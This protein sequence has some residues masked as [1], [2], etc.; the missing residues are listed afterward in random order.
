MSKNFKPLYVQVAEKLTAQFKEG[1]S[2][3]QKPIKENGL[4]AFVAPVNPIT[5]KGYSA[6]NAINLALKGHDDPRWMSADTASFNNYQVKE[7]SKGTLINFPKKNEIQA[8]RR[9]DGSKIKDDDGNTVTR[10]VEF[11]KVQNGKAFLFNATQIKDIPPLAEWLKATQRPG[12]LS[13]VEKAEKLIRDSGAVIVHG[14]EEAFYDKI[15]DE[16]HLPEIEQFDNDTRYY[17]AA[18]HQLAHWT[19][20]ESRLNRQ[21]DGNLGSVKYAPE[22]LRA[23][24]AAMLIG[25]ELKIGHSFGQHPAYTGTW[26]KMLKD[27]PFEMSRAAA[28]AQ[29]IA[30]KL[31]GREEKR[32][33]IQEATLNTSLSKGE[34]IPYNGTSYKVL[35][36]KGRNFEM[37]KADTG[38][39]FKLKPTDKLFGN[40]IDARNNPASQEMEL[41]AEQTHKIGR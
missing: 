18:I 20:H 17:Q 37:E 4:P 15:K 16:I 12:D 33:I 39:K 9:P 22:E 11:D 28:D 23:S 35:D 6:L 38:E 24:I 7:G 19:G 29:K 36:K 14:G 5:G 21:M 26:S 27:E 30:N 31:L 8:V 10:T 13:P 34:E 32:E 25:A 3:I 41:T 1:T 2:P 40:L